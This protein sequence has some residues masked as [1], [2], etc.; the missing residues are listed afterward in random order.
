MPAVGAALA[1]LVQS[2]VNTRLSAAGG[3]PLSQKNPSHFITMC[4]AIGM[5]IINGGPAITFTTSDSGSMGVPTFFVSDLYTRLRS[6]IIS[7]FGSTSHDPYPPGADNSGQF[8][9]ALCEGINDAI[10]TYYPTAWTLVSAHPTIYIG[11][12]TIS[13]GN[14]SGLVAS[15]IGAAIQ[16]GAPAFVGPF[17]P[18]LAMAIAESYVA[19]ITEHSTGMVT[20][21]GVCVPGPSQV[22]GISSTGSG[23]GVAT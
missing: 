10:Q 21:V 2:K 3:S 13:D 18:K 6:G 5:G 12:G 4:T 1:A 11:T 16:S 7:Q 15:A 19:L 14:F 8:L 20:I 17:W 23:S 22:C 9:L